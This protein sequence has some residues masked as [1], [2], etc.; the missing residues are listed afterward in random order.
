LIGGYIYLDESHMSLPENGNNM[1]V[2]KEGWILSYTKSHPESH[3]NYI[4]EDLGLYSIFLEEDCDSIL[5]SLENE[6][7]MWHMH[8][9]GSYSSEGN[10]V[11]I[12]LYSPYE[13]FII[14]LTD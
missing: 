4:E 8:F 2:I 13:I 6:D 1:N 9:D 12:I 3:I 7:G 5:P 14:F 11:G 10:G